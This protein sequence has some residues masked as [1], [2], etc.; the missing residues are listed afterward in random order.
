MN[1]KSSLVLGTT[2]LE[3]SNIGAEAASYIVIGLRR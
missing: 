3:W 2:S 1:S